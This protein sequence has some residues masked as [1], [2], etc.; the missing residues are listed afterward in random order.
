MNIP[1]IKPYFGNYL[2]NIL[3][4]IKLCLES[5]ELTQGHYL[6]EFETEMK[7]ISGTEYAIGVN[8]GGTALELVLKAICIKDKEVI[9]PT[10]T[11]IATASSVIQA[12]GKPMFADI[13]KET[14]CLDIEDVL[15]KITGKTAGIIMVHMFG[16][17]DPDLEKIKNVCKDKVL[18]LVEDAAHAHGA[19]IDGKKA[20][21]L[22]DAGCFSFYATKIATTGEGG[23]ITTNNKEMY[24]ELLR[25]RNHGKSLTEPV[26]E[27]VSNNYRLPEIPSIIG[28]YQ[29]RILEENI[30]RRNAIA[31]IYYKELGNTTGLQLLPRYEKLINSYWRF[32][33]LLDKEVDRK[34]L[35]DR[36][37][38]NH[39]IRITW[40]YEPLCHLQPVYTKMFGY[41]KG[42]LPVAEDCMNR[43]ICLPCYL[44]LSD[45]SVGRVIDGIKKEIISILE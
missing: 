6:S 9:V 43:L 39:Q 37:H 38:K 1:A 35:Q 28:I 22:G 42:D 40:M 3:E 44:G 18:F 31:N 13:R 16:L 32:P 45:E 7:N 12:G 34:L 25:L 10:D 19:S 2:Q 29:L 33:V 8:S 20:G 11:F 23:M 4:D 15:R 21:N 26:H 41:K 14:L 30:S 27:M 17:I 24:E 5:G 36:L